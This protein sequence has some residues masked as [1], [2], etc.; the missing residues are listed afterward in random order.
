MAA[1]SHELWALSLC[2]LLAAG[3]AKG[4][5]EGNATGQWSF[6]CAT[7]DHTEA[8]DFELIGTETLTVGSE[9]VET[10]HVRLTSTLTGDAEGVGRQDLWRLPGTALIVRE[11]TERSSTTGSLIGDV[12]Y[13]ERF[14]L[15]LQ[16]VVPRS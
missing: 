1:S 7:S 11:V 3:C 4:S 15:H 2:T 14:E 12:H 8:F 10:Q 16:S 6:Q 5:G 9:Q 13:E